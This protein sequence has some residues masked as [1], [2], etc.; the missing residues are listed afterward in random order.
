LFSSCCRAI[1]PATATSQ[2]S[3][4][5]RVLMTLVAARTLV[6]AMSRSHIHMHWTRSCFCPRH[7]SLRSLQLSCNRRHPKHTRD[8]FFLASSVLQ[9]VPLLLPLKKQLLLVSSHGHGIQ[10]TMSLHAVWQ[11]RASLWPC[12]ERMSCPWPGSMKLHDTFSNALLD[13]II[14]AQTSQPSH[15][16]ESRTKPIITSPL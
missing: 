4:A 3:N 8:D 9:L 5:S 7:M 16:Q 2:T 11:S 10:V 14:E 6:V 12:D 13:G 1:H 15:L